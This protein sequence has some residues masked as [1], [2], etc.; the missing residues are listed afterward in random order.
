MSEEQRSNL[1]NAIAQQLPVG[2]VAQPED[3]AA[4]YVYL[5]KNGFTTGTVVL[6]DGGALLS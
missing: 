4:A 5:A 6:I 3:I 2:R 1:F